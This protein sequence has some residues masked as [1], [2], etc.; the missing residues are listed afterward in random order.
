MFQLSFAMIIICASAMFGFAGYPLFVIANCLYKNMLSV[1]I[2]VVSYP[3]LK[4]DLLSH[5]WNVL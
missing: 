3:I 2:T 1:S 4:N 5:R